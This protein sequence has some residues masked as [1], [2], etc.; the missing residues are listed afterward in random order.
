MDWKAVMAAF[1]KVD[2]RGYL[3][4]EIGHDPRD[5]D[6]LKKVSEALDKILAMA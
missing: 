1:V 2:Y 3:S 4:P 5:P 6:Q